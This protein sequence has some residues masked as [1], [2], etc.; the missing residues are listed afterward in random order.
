MASCIVAALNQPLS[1]ITDAG[2]KAE[3]EQQQALIASLSA[4]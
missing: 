1:L 2:G 3:S 4:S